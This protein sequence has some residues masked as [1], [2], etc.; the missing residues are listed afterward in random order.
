MRCNHAPRRRLLK[1]RLQIVY[2]GRCIP[3][4]IIDAIPYF[5]KWKLQPNKIPTPQEQWECTKQVLF[6]HFAVE[7]PAVSV[8]VFRWLILSYV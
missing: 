1:S 3:W 5:R 8:S 6:S 7:L 2:F 4:I